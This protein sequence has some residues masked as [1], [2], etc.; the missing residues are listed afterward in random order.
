MTE[1][2]AMSNALK[3]DALFNSEENLIE[4]DLEYDT[5]GAAVTW[6]SFLLHPS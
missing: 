2:Y 5:S 4:V 3:N 6:S 1:L